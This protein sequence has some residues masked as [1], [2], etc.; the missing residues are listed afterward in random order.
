MFCVSDGRLLKPIQPPPKGQREV[1]FY[2]FIKASNDP[3]D[4][5]IRKYIPDFF[6][7]A[8]ISFAKNPAMIGDYLILKDI[9]EGFRQPNIMDIKIGAKTYGPDASESK[10]VQEDS[11]YVGT[12]GPFGYS[13]TGMIVHELNEHDRATKYDKNFGKNLKTDNVAL[14]PATFF[15]VKNQF[16]TELIEIMVEQMSEIFETFDK[17]RSYKMFASSLLLAYD[18]A[19]V[20]KYVQ[21][22]IDRDELCKWIIVR[23]ID[24]AHVFDAQGQRDDN[25]LVGFENLLNLFKACLNNRRIADF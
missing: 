3:V 9:T 7:V 25:F 8:K 17:Q 16:V 18:A 23:V 19:A 12:K 1:D 14:I 21:G 24:F 13:V 10:K 4:R 22:T 5:A 15:D 6:G 20:R 11:K 2:T